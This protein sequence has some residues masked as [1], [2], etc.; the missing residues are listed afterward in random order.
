MEILRETWQRG[1]EIAVEGGPCL[2]GAHE[3]TVIVQLVT[4]Q[5]RFFDYANGKAYTDNSGGAFLETENLAD[6]LRQYG[7]QI[8]KISF[9]QKKEGLT[10]QEYLSLRYP[11]EIAQSLNGTLVITIPDM[12]Y[13]KFLLAV[14]KFISECIREQTLEEFELISAKITAFYLEIID[15]LQ[16][17]FNIKR[18]CCVHG[19]CRKELKLWYEKRIPYIER[20]KVLR[21]LTRMP[22]KIESI[23]DYISM[24]AL[25]YYLFDI[26]NVLEV[27]S[28]DET[29]AFHKCK[30]AHKG[31]IQMGCILF[32][33]LLSN[34]NIN[35]FYNVSS[36]WKAFGNYTQLTNHYLKRGDRL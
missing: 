9:Q 3:V 34:D 22:E 28:V 21:N 16:Q 26:K 1:E 15:N 17:Q 29:D 31:T 27:N 33:E 2:F 8:E 36:D 5:M 18:F 32:P 23:K 14:L 6:Y 4:G 30:K 35:T 12:S 25:P 19:R 7:Q 13:C 24:P 10:L 20:K 11:F